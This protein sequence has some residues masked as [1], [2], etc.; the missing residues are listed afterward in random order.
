LIAGDQRTGSTLTEPNGLPA[1]GGAISSAL[2]KR[3]ATGKS[4]IA[5][6]D[7]ECGCPALSGVYPLLGA[8]GKPV[9]AVE[10]QA[11]LGP[12]YDLITKLSFLLLALG[13]LVVAIG[14]VLAMGI[15]RRLT[16]R[17]RNLDATASRVTALVHAGRPLGDQ[18]AAVILGGEDEV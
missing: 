15:G 9:G 5:T 13:A 8:N 6:V 3:I 17:L 14:I 11:E 12:L 16:R 4:N 10:L 7:G 1:L 2:R 18:Q